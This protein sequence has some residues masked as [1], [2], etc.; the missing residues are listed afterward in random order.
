MAKKGIRMS[1][2]RT[3]RMFFLE[4]DA[5][6]IAEVTGNEVGQLEKVPNPHLWFKNKG[7]TNVC[8]QYSYFVS[9]IDVFCKLC[10]FNVWDIVSTHKVNFQFDNTNIYYIA[11]NYQYRRNMIGFGLETLTSWRDAQHRVLHRAFHINRSGWSGHENNFRRKNWRARRR[12]FASLD[13]HFDNLV[14]SRFMI[15]IILHDAVVFDIDFSDPSLS[16][17]SSSSA[18]SGL[19]RWRK[20]ESKSCTFGTQ[21]CGIFGANDRFLQMTEHFSNID[22]FIEQ[23][24]LRLLRHDSGECASPY[25]WSWSIA[26]FFG[27]SMIFSLCQWLQCN[28]L[29]CSNDCPRQYLRHWL[30]TSLVSVQ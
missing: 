18:R 6:K 10:W 15:R 21:R 30:S 24:S 27:H 20:L 23:F 17:N 2:D 3:V 22:F 12:C 11:L 26:Y 19:S 13:R 8:F 7:I 14:C 1:F 29:Q 16:G 25:S 28:G 9:S 5:A 4:G